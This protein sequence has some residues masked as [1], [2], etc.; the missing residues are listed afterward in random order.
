MGLDSFWELP[1][2][3]K[4]AKF[5]PPLGLC[6][7]MFSSHGE[8]SFR[9]KAYDDLVESVTGV[10]LYQEEIPPRVVKKMSAALAAK[11]FESL[12]KNFRSDGHAGDPDNGSSDYAVTR[13]EYEDLRRMFAVYAKLGASLKGWW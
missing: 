4:K 6:G 10:S 3:S 9:G 7:G 5:S 12:P 8:G 11:E 13:E 1:K 2:E